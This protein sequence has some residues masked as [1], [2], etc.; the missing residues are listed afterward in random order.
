[1]TDN[2]IVN[3]PEGE[4]PSALLV[5]PFTYYKVIVDGRVIPRLTGMHSGDKITLIVDNRFAADFAPDDARQAAWLIAEAM[6]IGEGYSHA[7]APNKDR[8]FAPIGMQIGGS[9]D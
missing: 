4:K 7:G 2:N 3:F 8:S 1:M 9:D 5:G 6:A